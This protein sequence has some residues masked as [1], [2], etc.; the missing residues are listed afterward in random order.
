[1]SKRKSLATGIAL[2]LGIVAGMLRPR[3][4][5]P[6]EKQRLPELTAKTP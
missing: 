3:P 1:M 6:R 4:K 2:L 5:Q